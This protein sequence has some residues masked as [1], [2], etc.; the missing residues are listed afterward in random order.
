[1]ETTT[2]DDGIKAARE[3]F[4][5]RT[6]TD[7]QFAE[8]WAIAGILNKEIHRSGSFKEK[9]GDYV[10]AF[11]RTDRFDTARAAMIVRDV[12]KGR[13]SETPKQTLEALKVREDK[14][15]ETVLDRA[16]VHA[17]SIALMIQEGETRPFYQAYDAA[18]V[19]LAR[20][21]N[22]TQTGAKALLKDAYEGTH[23]RDLYEAGKE[24]EEAYHKPVREA[25]IT[26]RKQ[27][28]LQARNQAQADGQSPNQSRVRSQSWS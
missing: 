14:L 18:A 12:Y 15:P 24:I 2:K 4:S 20:E 26:A 10:H 13:F 9:L 23:Q 17:E 1:M 19:H 22:I 16:L 25:E 27:D 8:A 7:G 5:G 11:A 3:S 21:L 28:Q 6:L